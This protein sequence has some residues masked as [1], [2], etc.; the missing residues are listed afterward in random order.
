MTG[1]YNDKKDNY[2]YLDKEAL[3]YSFPISNFV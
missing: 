1:H 2:N 3:A